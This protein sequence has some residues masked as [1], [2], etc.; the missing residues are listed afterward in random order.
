MDYKKAYQKLEQDSFFQSWI[1]K[2][3]SICLAY[4]FTEINE[5]LELGTWQMGFY[6]KK[7][8]KIARFMIE[9]DVRF[10]PLEEAFKKPGAIKE[11][12]LKKVKISAEKA[13]DIALRVQKE[14]YTQHLVQKGFL[15]LQ[16]TEDIIWNITFL[17]RTLAALNIK[18]HAISGNVIKDE[19]MTFFDIKK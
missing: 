14:K 2:H 6:D 1:K 17:T 8:D 12:E 7:T 11:L 13:R 4:L 10:E 16:H 15:I 5:Q 18:V 9:N 19:L 3:P